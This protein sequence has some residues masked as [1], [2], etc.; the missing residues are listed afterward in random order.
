MDFFK[1]PFLPILQ[2]LSPMSKRTIKYLLAST[3][4]ILIL[5]SGCTTQNPEF[6]EI[7]NVKIEKLGFSSGKVSLEVVMYN[8][9]KFGVTL[10]ESSMDIYIDNRYLGKAVSN[11]AISI[12]KKSVFSVP[13]IAELNMKNLLSNSLNIVL[14]K[15]VDVRAKGTMRLTKARI[16]KN[17]DVDYTGRHKISVSDIF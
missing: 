7:R 17:I 16:S 11:K 13:V 14:S 1:P 2:S 12:P 8:P 15:E 5:I 4:P 3:L 9:N 10:T 6:R